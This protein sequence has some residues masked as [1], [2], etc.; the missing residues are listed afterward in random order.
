MKKKVLFVYPSMIL[1]GS[2][3][4]LLSL[5][6]SM[7]PDKY[8]IDLQLQKNTGPLLG[9]IPSHVNLLPEAQKYSGRKGRIIKNL[10]FVLEGAAFKAFFAGLKR[11]KLRLSGEVIVDFQAKSLSR[12]NP[13]HYDYAIGFLE[14]WSDRYLAHNVTADKKYAWLHSTFANIT[15]EPDSQLPWMKKVDK[16]VFVTEACTEDFKKTLPSMAD[17]AMTIENITDSDVIRKR[18]EAV[19]ENDEAYKLFASADCFKIVTVCRI[20]ISVKGLD[21]IVNCAKALKKAEIPFL[22]YIVG[23]G[24]DEEELKRMIEEAKVGDCLVPIGV[25]FNPYPFIK[26]ADIMCMPSRYEGKPMVITESM[27]LGVPPVVT[28]YLSARDQI[29]DG[30]DGIVVENSDE[31]I[32]EAVLQ[33]GGEKE[34]VEAMKSYLLNHEYGNKV[35]IKEIESE[36][37]E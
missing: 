2:T 8:Q 29:E 14:G 34:K 7:D 9:D 11:K 32:V 12:R 15:K 37:F 31:S 25:R 17:K 30:V 6:N 23:N 21:R 27:I 13:T 33:C 20:T 18:G 19:D 4:S 10:R 16:I 1:G 28:E 35:Y 24:N 22:W 36:L 5:M 26:A 3:T